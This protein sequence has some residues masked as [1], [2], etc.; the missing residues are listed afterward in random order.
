[1]NRSSN[2]K[3]LLLTNAC[4]MFWSK[5]YS[6]VSVR[7]ISNAAGVDVA[8]I[9]RYFGSKRGLFEATLENLTKIEAKDVRSSKTLIDAIV[10]LF[11]NGPKDNIEASPI[12]MVLTNSDDAEVGEIVKQVQYEYWQK[13][14]EE[15]IGSKHQAAM[16]FGAI[17]GF[18]VA[19]KSL[20]L[21]GVAKVGSELYRAQLRHMLET[22]IQSPKK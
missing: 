6:N 20:R 19:Q 2:T 5:G 13:G 3:D 11:S 22:A 10:E 1:M 12:S 9:T 14:L 18:C 16:F 8:L 17:M 7:E 4:K 15:I 21:D